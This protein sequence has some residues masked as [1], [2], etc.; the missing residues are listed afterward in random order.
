MSDKPEVRLDPATLREALRIVSRLRDEL[1]AVAPLSTLNGSY[2][3]DMIGCAIAAAEIEAEE[4]AKSAPPRLSDWVAACEGTA[5]GEP[6]ICRESLDFSMGL[7][8]D[9]EGFGATEGA[10][11]EEWAAIEV[12]LDRENPGGWMARVYVARDEGGLHAR[13]TAPAEL[14]SALERLAADTGGGK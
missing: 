11:P 1:K 10:D 7:F 12:H 13:C 6:G 4:L 8:F 9:V 3:F 14:R 5:L 2:M